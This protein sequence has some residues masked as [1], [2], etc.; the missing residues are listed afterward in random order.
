MKIKVQVWMAVSYSIVAFTYWSLGDFTVAFVWA[1]GACIS[2][3][4]AVIVK[5]ISTR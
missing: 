4:G 5:I 2:M 3:C 1:A